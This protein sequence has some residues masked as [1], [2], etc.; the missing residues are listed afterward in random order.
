MANFTFSLDNLLQLKPKVKLLVAGFLFLIILLIGF[1]FIYSSKSESLYQAQKKLSE[2]KQTLTLQYMIYSKLKSTSSLLDLLQSDT[3]ELSK[4][5]PEASSTGDVLEAISK[6][7]TTEGLTFISYKPQK[8]VKTAFLI[9][10]P[11]SILVKGT[12]PEFAKFVA[13]LT[14]LKQLI[15]PSNFTITRKDPKDKELEMSMSVNVYYRE[16]A[17]S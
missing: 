15:I 7:G 14:K 2:L 12:Y 4:L 3:S 17:K 6:K 9:E 16:K 8:E 5:I 1:S 11:I 13:D 10:A